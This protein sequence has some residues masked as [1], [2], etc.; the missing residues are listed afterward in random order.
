MKNPDKLNRKDISNLC[1]LALDKGG[2]LV[3]EFT[4]KGKRWIGNANMKYLNKC[5]MTSKDQSPKT[6]QSITLIFTKDN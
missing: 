1:K 2:D 3:I 4:S 6:K 5:E